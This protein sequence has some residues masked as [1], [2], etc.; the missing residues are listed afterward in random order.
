MQLRSGRSIPYKNKDNNKNK[1]I[2]KE[3]PQEV[4]NKMTDAGRSL[5]ALL[6]KYVNYFLEIDKKYSNK[7]SPSEIKE[8]FLEKTRIVIEM[9]SIGNENF[10]I[11]THE[12]SKTSSVMENRAI[13]FII[14]LEEQKKN[15]RLR[16]KNY[17]LVNN[18]ICEL[19]LF[20]NNMK[21][22]RKENM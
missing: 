20:L 6:Q 19:Y 11:L 8:R 15:Y 22:N 21:K 10:D 14:D 1:I 18:T 3:R 16:G 9:F 7:N 17:S 13:K 12:V 4:E 5:V 2:Q